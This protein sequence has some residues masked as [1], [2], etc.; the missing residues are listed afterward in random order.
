MLAVIFLGRSLL[1][2]RRRNG[3]QVLDHQVSTG[4]AGL[5]FLLS[6]WARHGS[7]P[8]PSRLYASPASQVSKAY[9]S[10]RN[11]GT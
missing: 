2:N 3:N 5:K 4:R 9:T 1:G 10:G 6:S 8:R 11:F 7:D